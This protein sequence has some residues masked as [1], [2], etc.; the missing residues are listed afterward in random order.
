MRIAGG[1][2]KGR[3]I[4][5]PASGL[6]PTRQV[7]KQAVFNLLR[8]VI[9]GARVCDLFC[10]A[11]ALGIEALSAGAESVVFVE[12]DRRTLRFL[13]ENTESCRDRTRIV[14]GEVLRSIPQ[15][16][17]AEFDIILADPPYEKRL[18]QATL[19]AG[20]RD[21]LLRT[22]GLMVLEHSRRDSPAEIPGLAL[23]KSR[24]FGD[25]VV[26]VFRREE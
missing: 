17:G 8:P 23:V 10:G 18:D 13:R 12:Q 2:N 21:N 22:D 25:T 19:D 15:L 26:S 16:A 5:Y 14:A 7:V 1:E 20:I 9:Q 6:R 4:R 11:G 24:R 3:R